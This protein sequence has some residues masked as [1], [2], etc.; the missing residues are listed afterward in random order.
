MDRFIDRQGSF[1]EISALVEQTRHAALM[2]PFY[3]T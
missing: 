1:E 2:N 3:W